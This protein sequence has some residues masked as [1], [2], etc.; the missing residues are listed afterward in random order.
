MLKLK[1]QYFGHLMRRA[2]SLEKTLTLRKTEDKGRK[3]R[4]RMR[5]LNGITDSMDVN[6]SKL[7][8]LV[9]DREAW[10]AAIHG[11]TKSQARLSNWTTVTHPHPQ[12]NPGTQGLVSLIVAIM[13][14]KS[15]MERSLMWGSN[16]VG[17]PQSP[18]LSLRRGRGDPLSGGVGRAHTGDFPAVQGLKLRASS[19]GGGGSIPEG[20]TQ[21]LHTTWHG[22]KL[23]AKNR[24]Q[25]GGWPLAPQK[26]WARE[27]SLSWGNLK[28]TVSKIPVL[29]PPQILLQERFSLRHPEVSMMLSVITESHGYYL[30]VALGWL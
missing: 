21:I 27:H 15:P 14:T 29:N 30:L 6:L 12:S 25:T 3:G 24:A 22:Q 26:G 8:E 16:V 1:L 23:K 13:P 4:Q 18:G 17:Q 9:M 11:V 5:W 10:C 20:E 2:N 7:Q 28:A 19:T